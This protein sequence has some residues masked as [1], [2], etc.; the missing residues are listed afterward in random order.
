M[1]HQKKRKLLQAFETDF[2]SGDVQ[3]KWEAVWKVL[4]EALP[5]GIV[6]ADDFHSEICELLFSALPNASQ[7]GDVPSGYEAARYVGSYLMTLLHLKRIAEAEDLVDRLSKFVKR[8][9]MEECD[10]LLLGLF[11]HAILDE[12]FQKAFASWEKDSALATFVAKA[13]ELAKGFQ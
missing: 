7:A 1:N 5:K 9:S 11:E 6:E 3:R 8:S 10:P 2:A 13:K 12:R 4:Y